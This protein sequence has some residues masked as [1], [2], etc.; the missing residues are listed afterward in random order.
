MVSNVL[1]LRWPLN[2]TLCSSTRKS[3]LEYSLLS[4]NP[5]TWPLISW[6][7]FWHSNL[8]SP[9]ADVLRRPVIDCGCDE[10]IKE[11]DAEDDEDDEDE[12]KMAAIKRRSLTSIRVNWPLL[13][14]DVATTSYW[15]WGSTG[16]S[17][18]ITSFNTEDTKISDSKTVTLVL[19][20]CKPIWF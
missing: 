2:G 7:P 10:D 13:S 19:E 1:D 18:A 15:I 5:L 16:G 11:E 8:Q 12:E 20:N 14:A 17:F 9:I 4:T 6:H 3:N